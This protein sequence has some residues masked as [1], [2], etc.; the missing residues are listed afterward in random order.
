MAEKIEETPRPWRVK[1]L[2]MAPGEGFCISH[3]SS[4]QN[5]INLVI[6]RGYK[7]TSSSSSGTC[8]GCAGGCT[9][10]SSNSNIT[11][12]IHT[13][14]ATIAGVAGTSHGIILA[15]INTNNH[16][17]NDTSVN[18]S[19]G[20]IV[21]GHLGVE[22]SSSALAIDAIIRVEGSGIIVGSVVGVALN[23]L[24]CAF[25]EKKL[26]NVGIEATAI[27]ISIRGDGSVDVGS[28]VD[29]SRTTGIPT[30][31]GSRHGDDTIGV[32]GLK[33]TVE[34]FLLCKPVC[35]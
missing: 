11:W 27:V 12:Y 31:E 5:I 21:D 7:L 29:V 23:L 10:I 4:V 30:G 8:C 32:G 28:N 26:A 22:T 3:L 17:R 13:A 15:S 2:V 16:R 35:E 1:I 18:V 20:D 33:T 25:R 9:T 24:E 19:F 34:G 6:Y 14:G